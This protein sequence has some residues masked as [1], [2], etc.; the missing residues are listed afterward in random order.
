MLIDWFTVL[1]Q[2]INFLVLVFLL[3]RFLYGPIIR[4]M[5]KREEMIASRLREADQKRVEAQTEAESYRQ[6]NRELDAMQEVMLTRAKEEAEA[7]KRELMKRTRGEVD[8]LKVRWQEAVREEK[9]SFIRNLGIRAGRQICAIAGKVLADLSDSDLEQHII[10]VFLKDLGRL[11]SSELNKIRESVQKSEKGIVIYS[12]FEIPVKDQ[13]EITRGIHSHVKDGIDVTYETS[14]EIL[15][16]I[17]IKVD[18]YTIGWNL[19]DY[20]K[21]LEEEACKAIEEGIGSKDK[22]REIKKEREK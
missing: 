5:D 9:D 7:D 13:H 20:L 10:T 3:K 1:A 17:E 22:G 12:T 15:C 19:N 6:K 16:G 2:I 18:G 8:E 21:T 11:D 14:P 4:A